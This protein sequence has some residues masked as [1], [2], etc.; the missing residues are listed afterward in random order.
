M[1]F[2]IIAG[3]AILQLLQLPIISAGPILNHR[4]TTSITPSQLLHI[5]PTS[6]T[7][8]GAPF[9]DECATASDVAPHISSSFQT[10][11]IATVGEQAALIGIMAFESGEF[12]FVKN[13]YPGRPGQGTRNMQ[14]PT[15]N[16]AYAKSIPALAG[17]LDAIVPSGTD[18]SAL[19]DDSLDNMLA[20]LTPDAYSFASAA[21]YLTTQCGE[22][23]RQGLQS[24]GQTGWEA[25]ITGCIQTEATDDRLAYWQKAVQALGGSSTTT[26]QKA[27][28]KRDEC[29]KI[30]CFLPFK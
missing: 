10:Y 5:A 16:I 3:V 19:S 29:V 12:K 17:Q 7:C 9:A 8:V 20:L 1:F 21:W 6:S 22:T 27:K 11:G 24:N 23:I 25:Y 18:A 30:E 26:G 4:Q 28:G 13:H 14:F 15:Y 2:T